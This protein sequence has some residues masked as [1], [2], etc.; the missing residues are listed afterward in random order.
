MFPMLHRNDKKDAQKT[1][2]IYPQ[3]ITTKNI[4]PNTTSTYTRTNIITLGFLVK[5]LLIV[6][7]LQHI[8]QKKK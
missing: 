4:T 2:F 7:Q 1:N 3:Q 8:N 5:Y 6:T